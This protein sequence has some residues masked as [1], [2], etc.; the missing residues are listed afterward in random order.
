MRRRTLDLQ[1]ESHLIQERNL[2]SYMHHSTC[3]VT[4]ISPVTTHSARSTT[5]W[6]PNLRFVRSWT[7][8]I[9]LSAPAAESSA[10]L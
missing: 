10:A 6:V 1:F 5:I 9:D 8:Y 7:G 2:C 4:A 3:C